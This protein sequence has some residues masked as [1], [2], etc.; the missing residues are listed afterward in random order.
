MSEGAESIPPLET[1]G[2]PERK[3]FDQRA[4][5]LYDKVGLAGTV[6]NL[7][8]VIEDTRKFSEV[9]GLSDEFLDDETN[10]GLLL[11]CSQKLREATDHR[12]RRRIEDF[13]KRL[14]A[15]AVKTGALD[16]KELWGSEPER[17]ELEKEEAKAYVASRTDQAATQAFIKTY[18][19]Q[20]ARCQETWK[21]K[22][23][24]LDIQVHIVADDVTEFRRK[25]RAGGYVQV[26][27]KE[28]LPKAGG[29]ATVELV[30]LQNYSAEKDNMIR[31]E[32]YHVEDFWE[33]VR[34]G[35]QGSILESVDEL[36]AEFAAG[37]YNE[38]HSQD[39]F[40]DSTYFTLKEFWDKLSYV[41]DLDFN[42]L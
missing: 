19:S 27:E 14:V 15:P 13:E 20:I 3:S 38:N 33:F 18:S 34:R 8:V 35:H 25:L 39:P 16:A 26:P 17:T 5:A 40:G 31:H 6:P 42:L 1:L 37:N 4:R 10:L 32:L 9:H 36:H 12:Y 28:E 29:D 21:A 22:G 2:Q 41:G 24:D 23:Y 7:D 11:G 30:L